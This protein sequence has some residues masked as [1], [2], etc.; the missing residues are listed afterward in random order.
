MVSNRAGVTLTSSDTNLVAGFNW[1]QSQALA[2]VF[3]GDP[4][5]DW[6][7]AALPAR[8]AFCMRDTAH[9]S[10]G[11]QVLGLAHYTRNMLRRFAEHI[12]ASRDWCTYWEIDRR[13]LPCP[14]DYR[15]D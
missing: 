3:K 4:V 12:S 8:E 11:A 9:Q 15:D 6:Y 10:T 14:A 7:E 2:Y 13:N 5:G 1:A